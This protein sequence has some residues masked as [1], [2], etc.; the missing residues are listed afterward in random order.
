MKCFALPVVLLTVLFPRTL[1]AQSTFDAADDQ[2]SIGCGHHFWSEK[3][4]RRE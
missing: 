3:G 4:R 1:I 2:F